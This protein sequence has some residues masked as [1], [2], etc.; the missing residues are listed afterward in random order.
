MPSTKKK[1]KYNFPVPGPGRPSS[2]KEEYIDQ[3]ERLSLL[4]LTDI[5][6][7]QFFKISEETFYEWQ[8]KFPS[9]SEAIDNGKLNADAKVAR[10]LYKKAVGEV[11][12]VEKTVKNA[13]GT[14]EVIKLN[15][16]QPSDVTAQK[17]WLS[18][19]QPKIWRDK[20][21]IEQSGSIDVVHQIEHVIVDP[22]P[23]TIDYRSP[24]KKIERSEGEDI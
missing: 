14:H 13:D 6:M 2:F 10:S 16:Q 5:Q 23:R 24:Q 18:N 11:L 7:A 9:F 21:H 22:E 17:M 8:R 3:V 4:G 15:I 12:Q 19:R 1:N 20:A